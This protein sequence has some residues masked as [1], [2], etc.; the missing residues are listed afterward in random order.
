MHK[1]NYKDKTKKTSKSSINE[2][3]EVN[4]VNEELL[5]EEVENHDN[6]RSPEITQKQEQVQYD[7]DSKR[8]LVNTQ[9]S[10]K[11]ECNE[12]HL[13]HTKHAGHHDNKS[14]KI[15]LGY[16][17]LYEDDKIKRDP[18]LIR[19]NHVAEDF[20]ALV[21]CSLKKEIW[22]EKQVYGEPICLTPQNYR[23][24]IIEFIVF[25]FLMFTTV[26]IILYETFSELTFKLANWRIE[27]LRILLVFFAQKLLSPEFHK[28][29]QK[30]K[31]T[32]AYKEEFNYPYFAIF[33]CFCQ[34]T[35]SVFAY[36]CLVIFMCLSDTAL[37][38]VMHF[39][40][41]AV[42]IEM[43]DWIGEL[44][45]KEFPDEGEKPENVD[46]EGLNESMTLYSKMSLV[47]ED[48]RIINDFNK[49]YSNILLRILGFI[50]RWFPW[51]LLPFISTLLFELLIEKFQPDLIAKMKEGKEAVHH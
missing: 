18:L 7:K 47:R 1:P 42:L 4:D 5:N 50:L 33:V 22:D 25:V 32:L 26:G 30:F 16:N 2:E 27:V 35:M 31:Y 39:A 10:P 24:M 8:L 36:I 41:I 14:E 43:D 34:M 23:Q 28:G 37:P 15:Y 11:K 12:K 49:P 44:I 51:T 13:H 19:D 3:E 29:S 48:L 17:H 40:E 45:V 46:A 38:L 6:M 20:Y 21:W 9:K